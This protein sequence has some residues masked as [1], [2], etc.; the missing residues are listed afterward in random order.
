VKG[1]MGTT[2]E[3]EEVERA[4]HGSRRFRT[5]Q[6]GWLGRLH[7][8]CAIFDSPSKKKHAGAEPPTQPTASQ[9]H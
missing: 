9:Q 7:R 2:H 5:E 8:A 6:L 4:R 3:K 1:R